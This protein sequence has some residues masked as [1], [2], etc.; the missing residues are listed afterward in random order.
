MTPRQAAVAPT[1]L[2]DL[3]PGAVRRYHRPYE[4]FKSLDDAHIHLKPG[5]TFA[6]L[7]TV[8]YAE[9]DLAAAK[10]LNDARRELFG[11]V[12]TADE[13]DSPARWTLHRDLLDQA[14]PSDCV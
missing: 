14:L 11:T 2:E 8:A 5:L 10:R 13:D 12:R 3:E 4:A 1:H 9:S 6:Q 7:D